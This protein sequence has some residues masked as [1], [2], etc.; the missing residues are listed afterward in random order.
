MQSSSIFVKSREP[1][2][3]IRSI[4]NE[5]CLQEIQ[6]ILTMK[7]ELS[8]MLYREFY[9][10]KIVFL[11]MVETIVTYV[12]P[13]NRSWKECKIHELLYYLASVAKWWSYLTRNMFFIVCNGA[14]KLRLFQWVLEE[15]F[16]N[17]EVKLNT[18]WRYGVDL[19]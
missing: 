10:T 9:L 18:L 3:I 5:G 11:G 4:P 13:Y 6:E 19:I 7:L 1:L 2:Q 17:W 16:N 12:I 8:A 14:L 15:Y